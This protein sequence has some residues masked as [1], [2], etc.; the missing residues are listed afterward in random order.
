M[1]RKTSYLYLKNKKF[2]YF[3]KIRYDLEVSTYEDLKN[4]E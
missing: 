3:L 2:I 1:I 4:K